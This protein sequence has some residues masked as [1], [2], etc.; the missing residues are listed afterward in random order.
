MS[1][2][3]LYAQIEFAF[4]GAP[5]L[6]PEPENATPGVPGGPCT[7]PAKAALVMRAATMAAQIAAASCLRI[8]YLLLPPGDDRNVG[9]S[10]NVVNY[11]R[12]AEASSSSERRAVEEEPLD[13]HRE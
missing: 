9:R 3:P 7:S 10:E 5:V 2:N 11:P 12:R 4:A 8:S 6:L 13:D 1:F